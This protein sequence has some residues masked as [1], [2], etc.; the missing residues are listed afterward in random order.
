MSEIFHLCSCKQRL[1][2]CLYHD[3]MVYS[4]L[5]QLFNTYLVASLHIEGSRCYVYARQLLLK[6]QLVLS[7]YF[8]CHHD[9]TH[10]RVQLTEM[11]NKCCTFLLCRPFCHLFSK[12]KP[13]S[14]MSLTYYLESVMCICFSY[15]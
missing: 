8:E 3:C 5:P 2:G 6:F 10:N 7:A 15:R 12:S 14:I 9:E 4:F 13:H 11:H 1:V